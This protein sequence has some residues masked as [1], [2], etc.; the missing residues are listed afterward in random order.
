M[1]AYS[2]TEI[3]AALDLDHT[4]TPTRVTGV[5]AL[6]RAT[7]TELSFCVYE[8]A[9]PIRESDAGAVVCPPSVSPGDDTTLL[10]A[11]RPKLAFAR[12]VEQFFEPERPT[13]VHPSAA[14]ADG[15]TVGADTYIGP[16]VTVASC[17]TI[18]E[19]C[20]IRA[21]TT[22]GSEGFGFARDGS[23]TPHRLPHRGRVR[24]EDGVEIGANC[25]I[26][27]AVFGETVVGPRAKLSGQVHLAHHVEIGADTLVASNCAFAGGAVLGD[28]VMCH[29][30]A[31]VAN[32]V[33]V[34]D[35]AELAANA[36][37]LDD[38]DPGTTV[39]GTPATPIR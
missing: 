34:G 23:G 25:S 10:V 9:D 31:A 39:A 15:A 17:V 3:A 16:N 38:V 12:A 29:P 8:D 26:D 22:L 37:V 21:G 33:R 11:E 30:H 32:D 28:R 24:I 4:G 18:G 27:R 5:D 13:G 20:T 1:D 7:A 36:G 6:D 2:T 35:D 19:G 14:V